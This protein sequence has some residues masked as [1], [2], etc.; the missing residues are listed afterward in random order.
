[1]RR[2]G[3]PAAWDVLLAQSDVVSLHLPL[4]DATKNLFSKERLA[5]M[6]P[7]AMLINASLRSGHLGGAAFDV[8]DTEPLPANSP[9][10]DCPNVLLTPHVAGIT[11]ESN[12]RVSTM[13]AAE[14]LNALG[15]TP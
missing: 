11:A 7:G 8:F 13:I 6:K 1:M 14:V 4:I 9:W 3:R 10:V 2:C 15:V 12:T 5:R